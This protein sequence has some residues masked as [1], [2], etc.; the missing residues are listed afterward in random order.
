MT[1]GGPSMSVLTT[2]PGAALGLLQR[3]EAWSW[4]P[5]LHPWDNPTPALVFVSNTHDLLGVPGWEADIV[6]AELAL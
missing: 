1:E 4:E 2:P 6:L 5:C 3:R